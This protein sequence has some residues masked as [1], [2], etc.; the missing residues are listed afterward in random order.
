LKTKTPNAN[1]RIE[2]AKTGPASRGKSLE[3]LFRDV[4]PF[5]AESFAKSFEGIIPPDEDMGAFVEEIY[6]AR[7]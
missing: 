3:E 7:T 4:K 2:E 6:K 1:A 5:N